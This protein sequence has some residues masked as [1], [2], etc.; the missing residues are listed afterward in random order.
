[1]SFSCV[2]WDEL[3]LQRHR[4][5]GEDVHVPR[6]VVGGGPVVIGRV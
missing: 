2:F 1:M 4:A 6:I 5:N 3:V